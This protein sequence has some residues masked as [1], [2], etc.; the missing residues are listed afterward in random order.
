MLNL[1]GTNNGDQTITLTDVTGSGTGMFAA[2]IVNNAITNAKVADMAANTIKGNNLGASGDPIDLTVAQ[3]KTMLNLVGT[4]TGDQTISLTGDVTGSG[5]GMFAA[6]IAADAVTNAKLANMAAN[7]L[8]ATIPE[9]RA[10]RL[11]SRRH[12]LRRYCPPWSATQEPVAQKAWCRR[13]ARE[14]RRPALSSR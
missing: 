13:R 11:I 6:A 7:T 12:R 1:A 10:I 14:T 5:T 2:T 8:K 3:V 9:R 4:N